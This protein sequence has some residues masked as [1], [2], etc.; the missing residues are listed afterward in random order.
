MTATGQLVWHFGIGNVNATCGDRTY[1]I[2][3]IAGS[4]PTTMRASTTDTRGDYLLLTTGTLL[5][6]LH[7]CQEDA[8]KAK[9][10]TV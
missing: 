10:G 4:E 5:E 9:G 7:A 3:A 8:D 2:S 6:C 1:R